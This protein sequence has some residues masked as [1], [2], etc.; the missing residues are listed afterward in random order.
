MAVFAEATNAIATSGDTA[1]FDAAMGDHGRLE[2][3]AIE[4]AMRR[5]IEDV[6]RPSVDALSARLS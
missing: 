5:A 2:C 6:V 1:R 3:A 4:R